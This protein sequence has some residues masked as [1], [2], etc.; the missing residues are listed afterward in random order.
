MSS[1]I[2]T[3]QASADA[4]DTDGG[5]KTVRLFA[6]DEG[7]VSVPKGKDSD[8]NDI[9]FEGPQGATGATG[10]T[11]AQGPAGSGVPKT[12]VAD[13]D[14]PSS[15][16]ASIGGVTGDQRL[17]FEDADPTIS[18]LYIFDSTV[19]AGDDTPFIVSGTAGKWI[20]SGGKYNHSSV[21]SNSTVLGTNLQTVSQ[22]DAEAGTDTATKLWTPERIQ[23]AITALSLDPSKTL[24][25]YDEFITG[26]EDTDE[27]GGS[28]WRVIGGGTGNNLT[29]VDGLAGHPGIIELVGGTSA[30]GRIT[31]HL[32][33]TSGA[34]NA[35]VLG[36]GKII[37]ET[38]FRII[39]TINNHQR[40]LGG[41]TQPILINAPITEGVF[42]GI[43]NGDTNWQLFSASAAV[44]TKLDSGLAFSTGVWVN[45]KFEVNAAG[46]SIEGFA[47]GVS[48]GTIATN[49][50]STPISPSYKSDAL[51]AGGGIATPFQIDYMLLKQIF[52]TPR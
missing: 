4:P 27:L 7:G 10:A 28:G 1:L 24:Q 20:A 46:T 26:T 38:V 32:G 5:K 35:M 44:T 47:N 16:L 51:T 37:F 49:I 22:A 8:G 14:D 12:S 48:F 23:Q 29:R 2:L 9:D 6:T 17:V 15:E 45:L 39:G 36:S 33:E 18:T 41:L 42:L 19:T 31:M 43:E 11:G 40:S 34:K 3:E 25:M 21:N 52:T 30:S 13:I 50:P